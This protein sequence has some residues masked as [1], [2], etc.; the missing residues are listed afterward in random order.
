MRIPPNLKKGD[1]VAIIATARKINTEDLSIGIKILKEWGLEVEIG[2][3]IGKEHHQYAGTD[4]ERIQDFQQMAD[5]EDIKA[6]ICARGGYGTVRIIDHIDFSKFKKSPKWIV[7]Y[8]D[9]TVIHS[10]LYQH[11]DIPSIHA[12]MPISMPNNTMEAINSLRRALFGKK[13]NHKTA[14]HPL[15]RLGKC[16]APIIGGNL[17][18][19]YSLAG[20]VSDINTDGKILFLEDLDEYLYHVDRMMMNLKRGGKLDKLAGLVVGGM[21][22]MND[23]DIPLGKSAEGIIAEHIDGYDYPV[24][25]NFPVGH[26]DDNRAIINGVEATLNVSKN[27]VSLKQKA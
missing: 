23:N 10:H 27:T 11:L 13:L 4:E 15:N 19:I 22:D 3:N 24:C 16:K 9:I 2:P 18:L 7:G 12:T 5:R 21:T 17:S 14:H 6:I 20:S 26:I 25:F 8:S 1:K